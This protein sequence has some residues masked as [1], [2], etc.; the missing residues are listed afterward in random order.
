M[1]FG[2]DKI[3][4]RLTGHINP[5]R[6]RPGLLFKELILKISNKALL[7]TTTL[8]IIALFAASCQS[9]DTT[10]SSEGES[11]QEQVEEQNEPESTAVIETIEIA[12]QSSGSEPLASQEIILDDAETTE[13]GLQYL[14]ITPGDGAAPQ[15]GDI[16]VMN[17]VGSLPDGTEVVNTY[18]QGQPAIAIIG[19]EQLLPGWEEGLG[20]MKAGGSAKIVIPPDLA[21]GEE[22]FGVIPPNSQIVL[23]VDLIS[24]EPAPKPSA[25]TSDDLVTTENGVQY[26]DISQGDGPLAEEGITAVTHYTIWVKGDSEDTFITSS[27]NSQPVTFLIG[28]VEIVFPGWDEGIR[29]MQQG[30]KRLLIVPPDLALGEMGSGDIPPNATLVMEIELVELLAPPEMTDVNP[31]DYATTESGLMY[32]DIEKGDGDTPEIGQTV[33]VHYSGWLEDGTLFDSSIK[34]G[35]PFSFALGQGGVIAGW[36]EGLSTMKVGGKRQLVIPP[37]LGYGDAGAGA[38]IPPGAT[39]IFE[40]ELL[41]IQE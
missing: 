21:F 3:Q 20:L 29:G 37:D 25:Y 12:P 36:D 10:K 31:D 19:R 7:W 5:G 24:V 35:E 1:C 14:E 6:M 34:R 26:Y 9:A 40:V 28:T 4:P 23:E 22:G 8:L 33:V 2:R 15:E 30:G 41:A 32:Y 17:V 38:V 27:S 13:S 18:Q 16:V 39:L 11:S